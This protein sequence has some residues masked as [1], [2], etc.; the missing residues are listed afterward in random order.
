M[1]NLES[2]VAPLTPDNAGGHCQA[3]GEWTSSTWLSLSLSRS[4]ASAG[5]SNSSRI[6]LNCDLQV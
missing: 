4:A 3:K 2:R 6:D 5:S 1:M